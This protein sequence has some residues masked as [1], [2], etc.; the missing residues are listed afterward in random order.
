MQVS[1]K[2]RPSQLPW[3]GVM[4]YVRQLTHR[5]VHRGKIRPCI[6]LRKHHFVAANLVL[7]KGRHCCSTSLLASP[8]SVPRSLTPR[9]WLEIFLAE[10]E[11]SLSLEM[12]RSEKARC[13]NADMYF[14]GNSD[15]LVV[16]EKRANNA[17][18]PMAAESV[19]ERRL[20]KENTS[21]SLLVR[22]QSRGTRSRG[23]LGVREIARH[24]LKFVL[25]DSKGR[26]W[27]SW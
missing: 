12:D 26:T 23:L 18:R 9:A 14:T 8:T 22:T 6:E 20:T 16:P 17:R 1:Y 3:P 15:S 11:T 27:H 2:V 19:K 21:Q 5:S 7:T 24:Y 13:H 10:A 4:R 25:H